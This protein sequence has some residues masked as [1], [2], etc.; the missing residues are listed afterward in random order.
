[1]YSSIRLMHSITIQLSNRIR[2][3]PMIFG[4]YEILD[5]RGPL[6]FNGIVIQKITTK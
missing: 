3:M 4:H 5:N 6:K 2:M 1:M